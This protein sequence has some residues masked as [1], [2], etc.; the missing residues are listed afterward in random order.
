MS[1]DHHVQ[2]LL[3]IHNYKHDDLHHVHTREV[4]HVVVGDNTRTISDIQQGTKEPT[5][6]VDDVGKSVKQQYRER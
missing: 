6:H 4:Q 5:E 1:I 3:A 2:H